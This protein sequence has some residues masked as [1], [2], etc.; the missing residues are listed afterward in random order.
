MREPVAPCKGCENRTAEDPESGVRDCHQRCE[1]Y[2]R[3]K[4]ERAAWKDKL[5]KMMAEDAVAGRRP[6]IHK[7]CRKEPR[8]RG[9]HDEQDY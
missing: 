4:E 3:F 8:V 6:W 9:R 7:H 2:M 1:K 5:N